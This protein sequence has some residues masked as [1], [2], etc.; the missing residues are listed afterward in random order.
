MVAGLYPYTHF[1]IF[2]YFID[3][4]INGVGFYQ[5]LTPFFF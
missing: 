3:V 1:G 2:K 4:I 5:K